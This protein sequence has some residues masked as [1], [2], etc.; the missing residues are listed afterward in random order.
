M[1]TTFDFNFDFTHRVDIDRSYFSRASFLICLHVMG[2]IYIYLS[3]HLV[4]IRRQNVYLIFGINICQ[5]RSL[6]QTPAV[7]SAYILY[8]PH[9]LLE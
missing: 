7:P 8:E 5:N 1:K 4:L 6:K 9:F 2:K 3:S